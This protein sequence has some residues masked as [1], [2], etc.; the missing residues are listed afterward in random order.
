MSDKSNTILGDEFLKEV[1]DDLDINLEN[2]YHFKILG[3]EELVGEVFTDFYIDSNQEETAE[4]IIINPVKV[5]RHSWISEEGFS[6]QHFFIEWNPCAEGPYAYIN[7]ETVISATSPNVETLKAYLLAVHDQY[8]P[9]NVTLS[10]EDDEFYDEEEED[11]GESIEFELSEEDD[12]LLALLEHNEKKKSKGK[13]KKDKDSNIVD[14]IKYKMKSI[15]DKN[16][17]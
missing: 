4:Y 10:P 8:Y 1:V 6:S 3:G 7:P 9:L 17:K 15:K 11:D 14:F 12:I 2:I 5:I 13:K 16:N